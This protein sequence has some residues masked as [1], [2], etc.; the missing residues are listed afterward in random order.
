[1][2]FTINVGS[3]NPIKI[4]AVRESLLEFY[5]EFELNFFGVNSG[6]SKQPKSLEEAL[7]GAELRAKNSF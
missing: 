5:S 3:K 4:D 7:R 1:M 2:T 6:V